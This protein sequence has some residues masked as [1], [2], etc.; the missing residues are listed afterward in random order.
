MPYSKRIVANLLASH[1]LVGLRWQTLPRGRPTWEDLG[2]VNDVNSD[3]E[4]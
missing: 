1:A 4:G 3:D 2:D